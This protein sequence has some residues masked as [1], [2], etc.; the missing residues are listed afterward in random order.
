MIF[1]LLGL[2]ILFVLVS[3][4]GHGVYLIKKRLLK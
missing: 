3:V 1:I 4:L 2:L